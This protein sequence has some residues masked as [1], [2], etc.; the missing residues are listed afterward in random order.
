MDA[1]FTI[2]VG[3]VWLYVSGPMSDILRKQLQS[4]L[5]FVVPGFKYT[6]T[7]KA[8]VE[9]AEREGR[10]VEWDGTKTLARMTQYGLRCPT[11]LL[12]Y[13]KEIFDERKIPFDY[14]EYRLPPVRSEGWS[15]EGF[16]LFDYQEPP[17]QEI[18]ERKRGVLEISTGG[19]KTK[20]M[21][22]NIVDVACF[23]AVFY[24]PNTDLLR[25]TH[26]S[27]TKHVRYNG[28]PTEIGMV[29]DGHY[30]IR[31]ITICTVQMAQIALEGKFT[32]YEFDD[33]GRK[34]KKIRVPDEQR[35][36]IAEM[37]KTAQYVYI[38]ECFAAHS[39][40]TLGDGVTKARIAT[41]VN[42]K[43]SGDVLSWNETLGKF[44][45]KKVVGWIRKKPD[46]PILR[47]GIGRAGGIVCT[48][49]HV[50]YTDHG[51]VE[52]GRICQGNTL[53][54]WGKNTNGTPCLST[55]GYQIALGTSLGDGSLSIPADRSLNARLI[56]T[57]SLKQ[58]D[59]LYY[60]FSFLENL[61]SGTRPSKSGYSGE[62]EIQGYS[63]CSPEFTKI[64]KMGK[65]ERVKNLDWLGLVILF[66]DDGS[67]NKVCKGGTI[68]CYT[69]DNDARSELVKKLNS[70]GVPA[71]IMPTSK[72]EIV[73][74]TKAGMDVF[75]SHLAEF[76]PSC[77]AYKV[78]PGLTLKH[79]IPMNCPEYGWI[80]VRSVEPGRLKG[81][82]NAEKDVYCLEVEDNH[83]FVVNGCVV[84]N[85]QHVSSDTIQSVLNNSHGARYRI[86][87]SASPWR[88]DGLDILI[89]ACFGKRLCKIDASFLIR[90]NPPRLIQPKI[91]FNHF[92]WFLGHVA[93]Y[94][95]LYTRFIV[96][97]DD[98]NEWIAKRALYHV[99]E[100]RPTII[101]VKWARHASILKELIPGSEVLTSTGDDATTSKQRK[102]VLDR[103]RERKL[104]CI[105]GTTLLDEGIDIPSAGAGIFAGAGKSS[106][107]ALQRVGR[108]IRV[109]PNDPDKKCAYIE[110]F[111]DHCRWL[112][113]HAQ[114]RR[115]IYETEPEFQ[116]SD[117]ADPLGTK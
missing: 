51:P 58:R 28:Q 54:S 27:F 64:L 40:V 29:G 26:E 5:S 71:S 76:T 101:L 90:R 82:C 13:V 67:Y 88:D 38:D 98:R 102:L 65:A 53:L 104:M 6:P 85:C 100:G 43:Y 16:T 33:E 109:D 93:N 72:G 99:G 46:N 69:F 14:E 10:P 45:P 15:I 60:K 47:I 17:N 66:L 61:F 34:E 94:Q 115:R 49:N 24:V 68:A 41:L 36:K 84:H 3:N 107:R 113:H 92:R 77:L 59:Y 108:F 81:F 105:I 91:V 63:K 75:A 11:G 9:R 50:F 80:T 48:S 97:N 30:D 32:K 103:M 12:S 21:M 78:P 23:P 18:K 106:T 4:K 116:I 110:E 79:H 55:E 31:P 87:G 57:H 117:N 74:I 42:Q 44:E 56:I 2:K 73:Y 89:E 25:Q 114:A 96:E 1:H 86:G 7:Y 20:L 83:T 37:V 39:I 8:M 70:L 52:A 22:Q 62:E 19:G 95:E 112:N 111:Y 35:A